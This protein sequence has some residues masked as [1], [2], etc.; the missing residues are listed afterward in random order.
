MIPSVID[1]VRF[2][3]GMQFNHQIK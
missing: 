3:I 1:N 2:R